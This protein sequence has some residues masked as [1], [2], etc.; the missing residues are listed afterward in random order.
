ML[1]RF[2]AGELER[3]LSRQ[4]IGSTA[5]HGQLTQIQRVEV[6]EKMATLKRGGTGANQYKSAAPSI[7]GAANISIDRAAK[8]NGVSP[9]SLE[10]S[11]GRE[12]DALRCCSISQIQEELEGTSE[13]RAFHTRGTPARFE[14]VSKNDEGK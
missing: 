3:L 11:L 8:L 12:S 7:D 10:R 9:T 1:V 14:L 2:C 4:W 13:W 5:C 6:T